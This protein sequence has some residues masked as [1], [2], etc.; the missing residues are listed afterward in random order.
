MALAEL[1]ERGS[2]WVVA[3]LMDAPGGGLSGIIAGAPAAEPI[4]NLR[5]LSDDEL[6]ETELSRSYMRAPKKSRPAP[7]EDDQPNAPLVGS[8]EWRAA[9]RRFAITK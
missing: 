9:Q 5:F 8:I 2:R 4:D 3:K 1:V 7:V 6:L